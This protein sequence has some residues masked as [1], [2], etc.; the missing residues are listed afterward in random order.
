MMVN[1]NICNFHKGTSTLA[2]RSNGPLPQVQI[3]DRSYLQKN[4]RAQSESK[5]MVNCNVVIHS[6]LQR[7]IRI[8]P[9]SSILGS[10]SFNCT[11][12]WLVQESI[13]I[14]SCLS[15]ARWANHF[16]I[17]P[18]TLILILQSAHCI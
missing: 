6:S 16:A 15:L 5:M 18:M 9:L 1:I 13:S 11:Y 14:L 2:M 10:R 17:G 12:T 7:H 4:F 3:V 8:Q